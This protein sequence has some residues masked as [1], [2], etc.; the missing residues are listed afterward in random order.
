MLI[1]MLQTCGVMEAGKVYTV[2]APLAKELIHKGR[3]ARAGKH[4][5]ETMTK[6][7]KPG[8]LL[9]GGLCGY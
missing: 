2:A 7:M 4:P 9:R 5:S 3:A 6:V 1:K 8:Q